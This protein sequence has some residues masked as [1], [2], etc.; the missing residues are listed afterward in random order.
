MNNN[1]THEGSDSHSNPQIEIEQNEFNVV[2]MLYYSW[3]HYE[4]LAHF[5]YGYKSDEDSSEVAVQKAKNFID[6]WK[7]NKPPYGKE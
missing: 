6:L 2:V 3:S 1:S 7:L 4:E 5:P